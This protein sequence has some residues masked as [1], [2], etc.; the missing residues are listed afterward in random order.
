MTEFLSYSAVFIIKL[1]PMLYKTG[2][3]VFMSL[4]QTSFVKYIKVAQGK[5][6]VAWTS[7]ERAWSFFAPPTSTDSLREA[8]LYP[9]C[10]H[11]VMARRT[12]P[13]CNT[14]QSPKKYFK[15][16]KIIHYIWQYKQVEYFSSVL[17]QHIHSIHPLISPYLYTFQAFMVKSNI[18]ILPCGPTSQ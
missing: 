1:R 7:E 9:T 15:K 6:I 13:P 5:R 17:K 3:I 4:I 12:T 14:N 11:R 8:L 10:I 18:S 16:F 2:W